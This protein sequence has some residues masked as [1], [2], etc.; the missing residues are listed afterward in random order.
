MLDENAPLLKMSSIS[1]QH[2]GNM[3]FPQYILCWLLL[4]CVVAAI[5]L[6]ILWIDFAELAS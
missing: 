2:D 1:A 5:N 3:P 4:E 6:I